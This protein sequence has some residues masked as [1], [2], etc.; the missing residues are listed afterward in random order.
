MISR[1]VIHPFLIGLFPTLFLYAHNVRET[2][3]TEVLIPSAIILG[4]TLVIWLALRWL[5]KS[6]EKAGFLVSLFLI[7]FFSWS[8]CQTLLNSSLTS[9]HS[10]WVPRDVNV[11]PL[12]ILVGEM[13]LFASMSWLICWKLKNPRQVMTVLNT[14]ALALIVLP[15]L[16]V[17]YAESQAFATSAESNT[18]ARPTQTPLDLETWPVVVRKPDIYYIVL[19]GYARSDMM[20]TLYGFDNERFLNR[21][22]THGFFVAR[23]SRANYCQTPLCMAS[24][25]NCNYLEPSATSSHTTQSVLKELIGKNTVV[26]TLRKYGY[27]FVSFSTGFDQTDHPDADLYLSPN[28]PL[29]EFQWLLISTTPL[30]T[31]LHRPSDINPYQLSR[32]RTLFLLDRLPEIAKMPAPTFTFAHIVCPHPPF[33]FGEQGEDVSPYG[34]MYRLTDGEQFRHFYG[35]RETYIQGYRKQAA[36]ITAQVE[37]VIDQILANSPQQPI[38]IIQS[39]H[40]SGMELNTSSMERSDL[41]ERMSI[42]NAYYLPDGGDAALY[43]TITPVNSFRIVLNKYFGAHLA[44]LDDKS[45]YSTWHEPL[46]FIDVTERLR[47]GQGK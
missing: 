9:M 27:Q 8:H 28:P 31:M 10:L 38:I 11:D 20:K 36:F 30:A 43:G 14:F 4:L 6:S 46:N 17:V 18:A 22:K 19:D 47:A 23:D 21:L 29:T 41:Q 34:K 24:A 35:D 32:K 5:L 26:K 33:V 40:G 25:L 2:T 39:D 15:A 13:M 37:R 12:V 1:W 7:L 44:L 45:F 42:L 3:R 16:S